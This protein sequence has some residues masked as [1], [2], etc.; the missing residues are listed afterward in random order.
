MDGVAVQGHAWKKAW[1]HCL[2]ELVPILRARK[3]T[4]LC[5][6]TNKFGQQP[7]AQLS[8]ALHPFGIG[9][10]GRHSDSD[11]HASIMSAGSYAHMIHLS[12]ESDKVYTDQ[13]VKYEY[14]AKF[15]DSPDSLARCLE[16]IGLLKGKR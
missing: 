14:G 11:K 15:D 6:E 9:V 10:V 16:W 3:V 5:F 13:V 4:R 12:K 8:Q 1:Y 7:I 2:D